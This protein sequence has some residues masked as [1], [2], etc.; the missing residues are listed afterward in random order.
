MRLAAAAVTHDPTDVFAVTQKAIASSLKVIM[1][2]D[3]S[4]GIIGDACRALLDL[5]PRAA[6]RAKP[7]V[8]KLVDWMMKFQFD[9]E[10]DFFS[11]DPVAYTH[12]LGEPGIAAYRSKLAEV[13]SGLGARPTEQTRWTSPHSHEWVTLDWNARRLAVYDRDVEGIIRTHSR[14]RQVA[15]WLQDT[16]E[17][18]AE[19][20]EFDLAI[21]WARQ[22]V[23]VG[24]WHQ[25]LPAGEYWCHLL[26]EHRP[27]EALSARL[28][29]FRRWPSSGTAD[30][31]LRESRPPCGPSRPQPTRSERAR[32]DRGSA[33]PNRCTPLE[34]DAQTGRGIRIRCRGR[35][36]HCRTSR[37]K[38]PAAST[39]AGIRPRRLAL[40]TQPPGLPSEQGAAKSGCP[41]QHGEH[42]LS[43]AED[44]AS[45]TRTGPSI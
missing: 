8:A 30:H 15:R 16:A 28:E 24:P 17:A 29:V 4:S 41:D 7:P 32:R 14:D 40:T 5:H 9:N 35:L 34:E 27:H 25:S 18:L 11:V 36:A 33:L 39:S 42:S 26:A 6:A 22:A 12:A 13:E 21:D 31:L 45:R 1:R 10:C 23:D 37:I 20:G 43:N 44:P 3:D 2:A 19:I 38:P